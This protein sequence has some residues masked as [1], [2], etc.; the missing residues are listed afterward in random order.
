MSIFTGNDYKRGF[1]R[2]RK[3]AING[4]D[5]WDF[6]SSLSSGFSLKF[7]IHGSIAIDTFTEGYNKGYEE[8][9]KEKTV[10]RKVEIKTKNKNVEINKSFSNNLNNNTMSSQNYELQLQA[11]ENLLSFLNQFKQDLSDRMSQY[12]DQVYGLRQ[13]GLESHISDN[14]D[15]NFCIPTNQNIYRIIE[16]FEQRDFPFIKENIERVKEAWEAAQKQ[17]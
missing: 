3:D 4:K 9:L 11:L 14:Y 5:K 10:V 8:G 15:Q 16:N 1:E 13:A 12:N 6:K 7:A 2:G 17:Y